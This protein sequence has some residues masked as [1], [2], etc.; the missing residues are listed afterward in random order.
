MIVNTTQIYRL[1]EKTTQ[2]YRLAVKT[3]QIYKLAV[4]VY[5][6]LQ[7]DNKNNTGFLQACC[8]NNSTHRFKG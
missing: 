2:I 5:T 1:A 3:T 7:A 4:K 8:K 6:G